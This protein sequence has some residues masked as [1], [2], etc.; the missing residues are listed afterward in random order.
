MKTSYILQGAIY[1]S[2]VYL[3]ISYYI[4]KQSH[5]GLN[6]IYNKIYNT[7]IYEENHIFKN[8][9]NKETI[10]VAYLM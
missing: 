1:Y 8:H 7:N 6:K 5:K 9:K 10:K 2:T 4:V 3:K